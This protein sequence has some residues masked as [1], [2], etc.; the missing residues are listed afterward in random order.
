MGHSNAFADPYMKSAQPIPD[1][2][3]G[4]TFNDEYPDAEH[5]GE[6]LAPVEVTALVEK[7]KAAVPEVMTTRPKLTQKESQ[8]LLD[9][10]LVCGKRRREILLE[11]RDGDGFRAL[12]YADAE[13]FA[14]EKLGWSRSNYYQE[15]QAGQVEQNL[16]RSIITDSIPSKGLSTVITRELAKLDPERQVQAFEELTALSGDG[17]R[18]Q[19]TNV[20]HIVNRL[21]GGRKAAGTTPP[22]APIPDYA[23]A[24]RPAS[25]TCRPTPPARFDVI[26][27]R[28]ATTVN[29]PVTIECSRC[30]RG[31]DGRL[32]MEG[33]AP[34]GAC[35][36]M[37]ARADQ[38]EETN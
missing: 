7:E 31:T 35:I 14:K 11:L 29:D 19:R 10:F 34:D 16:S 23:P 12:G 27:D 3:D 18:N 5:D 6:P 1:T 37:S 4:L 2:L 25:A 17:A 13:T 15:L 9:E 21:G 28:P 24:D 30:W 33:I 38:V 32:Y 36:R 26:E 22:P 8:A 20:K